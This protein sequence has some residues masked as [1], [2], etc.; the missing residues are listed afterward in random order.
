MANTHFNAPCVALD[1]R[2]KDRDFSNIAISSELLLLPEFAQANNFFQSQDFPL[3]LPEGLAGSIRADG[4]FIRLDG[5][6]NPTLEGYARLIG[7][8][9]DDMFVVRFAKGMA[10]DFSESVVLW[11]DFDEYCPHVSWQSTAWTKPKQN[12]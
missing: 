11:V 4:R 7:W 9:Y 5:S 2:A 12:A 10:I 6:W 3:D 8:P 1:V